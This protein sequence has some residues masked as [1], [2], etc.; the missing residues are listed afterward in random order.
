[1]HNISVRVYSANVCAVISAPPVARP[2]YYSTSPVSVD[3]STCG[4]VSPARKPASVLESNPGITDKLAI[5]QV[6]SLN[7][8][9]ATF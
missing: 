2:I 5:T 1:M 7:N 8:K 3:P 9:T 6:V 4:S